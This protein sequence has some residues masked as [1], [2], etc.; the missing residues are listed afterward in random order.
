MVTN[1]TLAGSGAA[2]GAATEKSLMM[3]PCPPPTDAVSTTWSNA[4]ADQAPSPR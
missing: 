3:S 1:V 2:E 4:T